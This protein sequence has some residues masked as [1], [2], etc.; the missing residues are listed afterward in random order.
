MPSYPVVELDQTFVRSYEDII[1][2]SANKLSVDSAEV[3]IDARP[4]GRFD[5]TAPEPRPNLP[6]G[7]IPN[8]L[9]LPFPSFLSTPSTTKPP[10]ATL[11]T[12][13]ELEKAFVS[14]LGPEEWTK[15]KAGDRSA[16]A[17]CGSGMSA[18]LV[19]LALQVAGRESPVG[20]FDEVSLSRLQR[21]L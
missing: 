2:N 1:S 16:V 15:V 9:S 21:R 14:A 19:W 3:V 6:S 12:P 20:I 13:S 17:T 8:S 5:G 7:H 11:K 18:G 10:Y 4:S